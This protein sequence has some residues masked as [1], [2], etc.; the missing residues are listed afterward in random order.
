MT[1]QDKLGQFNPLSHPQ[2]V[3]LI[4]NQATRLHQEKRRET[5][6]KYTKLTG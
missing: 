6:N 5:L 1:K 4:T 3:F 2:R